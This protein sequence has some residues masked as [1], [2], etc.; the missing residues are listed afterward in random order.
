MLYPL[1]S[2][3]TMTLCNVEPYSAVEV[4]KQTKKIRT[5]TRLYDLPSSLRFL[6]RT[7]KVSKK[8]KGPTGEN[9]KKVSEG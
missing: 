5:Y 9:K 7:K 8:Q 2:L 3:T 4:L 6:E 1:N